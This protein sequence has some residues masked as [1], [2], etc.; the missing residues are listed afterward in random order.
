[1]EKPPVNRTEN[2]LSETEIKKIKAEELLRIQI[3]KE[4]DPPTTNKKSFL[5]FLNSTL[6]I[7]VLSSVALS[8]ITWGY[9]QWTENKKKDVERD[10]TIAEMDAE[11]SNRIIDLEMK[12]VQAKSIAQLESEVVVFTN[13]YSGNPQTVNK[14]ESYS[15]RSLMT[16]LAQIVDNNSKSEIKKALRALVKLKNV[17]GIPVSAAPGM[18]K[19]EYNNM[20]LTPEDEKKKKQMLDILKNEITLKRWSI[21]E[22]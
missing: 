15:V 17:Y 5:D 21:E 9:T 13:Y 1:M 6:G 12:L 8:L 16:N 7:W 4:I 11:I 22:K 19:G 18:T 3:R 10:Q 14:F 20:I 2:I